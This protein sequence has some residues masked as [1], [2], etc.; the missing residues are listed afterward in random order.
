MEEKINI[1]K[2]TYDAE[3]KIISLSD[4]FTSTRHS[5]QNLAQ[6][7]HLSSTIANMLTNCTKEMTIPIPRFENVPSSFLDLFKQSQVKNEKV[8]RKM[9][10]QLWQEYYGKSTQGLCWACNEEIFQ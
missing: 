7:Y 3:S 5:V 1:T 4:G 10:L 6:I 8:S 9:R 2:I